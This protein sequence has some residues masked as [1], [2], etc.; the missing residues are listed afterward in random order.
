MVRDR[1]SDGLVNKGKIF[2]SSFFKQGTYS[3]ISRIAFTRFLT[4]FFSSDPFS[5][6]SPKMIKCSAIHRKLFNNFFK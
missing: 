6:F 3:I 5:Q 4:D 2:F 1:G